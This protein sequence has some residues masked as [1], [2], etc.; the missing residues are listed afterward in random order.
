MS[1]IED[2]PLLHRAR[3]VCKPSPYAACCSCLRGGGKSQV[4]AKS[5]QF[6]NS[7]SSA[8]GASNLRN[9]HAIMLAIF[10]PQD[11]ELP[12]IWMRF[13]RHKDTGQHVLETACKA[14]GLQLERGRLAGSPEKVNLFTSDGDLL[15]T[16]LE[17]EAHS[18]D[19]LADGGCVIIEKGNRIS[20]ERMQRIQDAIA[21]H[22]EGGGGLCAVM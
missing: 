9:D 8:K 4:L 21:L 5:L 12:A 13:D 10:F 17:I 3:D 18:R 15:R 7:K 16:D 1:D 20:S 22:Q 2:A 14:A 6:S 11:A 19:T